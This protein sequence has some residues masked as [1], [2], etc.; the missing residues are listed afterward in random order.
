MYHLRSA[1][2]TV[3]LEENL[4]TLQYASQ[5]ASIKNTPVLNLDPKDVASVSHKGLAFRF[6]TANPYTIKIK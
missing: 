2:V 3:V 4:S 6:L 1:R 5:A